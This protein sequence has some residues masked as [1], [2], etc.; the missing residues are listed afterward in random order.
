MKNLSIK[1]KF[2]MLHEFRRLPQKYDSWWFCSLKL[3]DFK[4]SLLM[5]LNIKMLY[6]DT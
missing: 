3:K 2:Y 5:G 6:R 4:D 1:N